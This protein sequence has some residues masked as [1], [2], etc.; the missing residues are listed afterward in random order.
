VQAER[1]TKQKTVFFIF[2]AE[3]QPKLSKFSASR[4]QYKI[5]DGVLY[6]YC[7]GAA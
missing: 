3:A 5:K 2:I 7:R 1:N 6:F 4:A